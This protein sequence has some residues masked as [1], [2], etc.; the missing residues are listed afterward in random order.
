MLASAPLYL[1]IPTKDLARAKVF[2]ESVLGLQVHDDKG[3]E[4]IFLAGDVLVDVFTSEGAGTAAHTL[5][6]FMVDDID[7]VVQS[8]RERGV[9]FEDYD[10][11]DLRTVDGIAALGPDKVAWFKDPDGN[12]LAISQEYALPPSG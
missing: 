11:P 7:S 2:Y 3:F 6:S 9:V 5:A 10:L 12:I 1:T 8:L 4:V